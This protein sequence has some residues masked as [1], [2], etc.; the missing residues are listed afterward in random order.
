MLQACMVEHNV[1]A[2]RAPVCG[3][4]PQVSE[5][6]CPDGPVEDHHMPAR[7]VLAGRV[8]AACRTYAGGGYPKP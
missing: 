1:A 5:A 7:V 6:L 3:Q 2:G 8:S 4:V